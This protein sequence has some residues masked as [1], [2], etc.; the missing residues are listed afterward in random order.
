MNRTAKALCLVPFLAGISTILTGCTS[1]QEKN[2]LEDV[3]FLR[4]HGVQPVILKNDAGARVALAP[5]YQGRVMTSTMGGEN[6]F[7]CGWINYKLIESGKPTA[8]IN[9]YG[10]EDRFWLGPEGGPF[11]L[12]F[13]K[14]AEYTFEN[15]QVPAVFDTLPW[16]VTDRDGNREVSLKAEFEQET[17]NGVLR[18]IR[19]DRKVTLL[20]E[21]EIG[22]AVGLDLAECSVQS[23]GYTTANRVTNRG[24][25]WTRENGGLSIWMLGMFKPSPKTTIVVPFNK[26]AEGPVVKDDYFGKISPDRLR[27]DEEKG[28]IYF[29]ADGDSR[30]KIGLSAQR[31]RE[32]LGSYDAEHRILT[33]VR[34]TLPPSGAEY[35]N[36]AWEDSS[37]PYK[38]DVVNAYNDGI[39]GPGLPKM[40]PFYELESSSPAAFLKTGESLLHEHTTLHFSG[41]SEDL[42][43]IARKTLGVTIA[44]ITR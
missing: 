1:M 43:K 11:S 36:A 6:G 33:I 3:V 28:V 24:E 8:H 19:L 32:F 21:E 20:S 38:G 34:Y 22:K 25:A 4:E 29:C 35:A 14:G 13:P 18:K 10:G 27:I 9:A 31:A 16:E 41:S 40:G 30:G 17:R 12:Y 5:L 39:P 42:D 26:Q 7:S 2:F 23:V 15:W 37:E 44:D